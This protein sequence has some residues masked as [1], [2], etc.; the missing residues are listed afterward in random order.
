M[1]V[2][3][4][5]LNVFISFS[6]PSAHGENENSISNEIITENFFLVNCCRTLNLFAR[7]NIKSKGEGGVGKYH[8]V[9]QFSLLLFSSNQIDF[10][11]IAT[12][13]DFAPLYDSVLKLRC[14]PWPGV[15]PQRGDWDDKIIS[16]HIRTLTQHPKKAESSK[17]I[18]LSQRNFDLDISQTFRKTLTMIN[19]KSFP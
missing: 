19:W 6:F 13:L 10:E 11:I 7:T 14:R 2:D 5:T 3:D 8:D 9:P 1:L 16:C 17:L 18:N 15:L 4:Y 12:R